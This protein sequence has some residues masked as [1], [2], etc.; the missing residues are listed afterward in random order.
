MQ[1]LMSGIKLSLSI[2]IILPP[3]T[4]LERE[5]SQMSPFEFQKRSQQWLRLHA[6]S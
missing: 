5:I 3:A 2:K 1:I 6:P 4:P